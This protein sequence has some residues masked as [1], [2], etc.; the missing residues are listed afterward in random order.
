[1]GSEGYQR[2]SCYYYCYCIVNCYY[3]MGMSHLP[4]FK[5][6]SLDLHIFEW[7]LLV[8]FLD[9]RHGDHYKVYN[10]WVVIHCVV[11]CWMSL[12]ALLLWLQS[13]SCR[14]IYALILSNC[15]LHVISY[16]NVFAAMIHD[17]WWSIF[18]CCHNNYY[19]MW[20]L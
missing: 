6:T 14:F 16:N 2:Q 5:S 15:A 1:M 20:H 13:F 7:C 10:L 11:L 4:L 17:C 3:Y 9:Q 12:L 18:I 19:L 8:R